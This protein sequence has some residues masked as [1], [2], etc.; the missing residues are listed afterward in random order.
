MLKLH[1]EVIK[2]VGRTFGLFVTLP[3]P[4]LLSIIQCVLV[5]VSDRQ[6]ELPDHKSSLVSSRGSRRSGA[7]RIESAESSSS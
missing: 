6:W 5:M 1:D 7:S 4:V 3:F 2:L